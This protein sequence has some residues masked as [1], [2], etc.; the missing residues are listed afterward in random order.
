MPNTQLLNKWLAN[1]SLAPIGVS[2]IGY[3]FEAFEAPFWDGCF[4]YSLN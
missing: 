2:S 3:G 1:T 4:L